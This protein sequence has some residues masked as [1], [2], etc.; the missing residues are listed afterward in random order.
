MPSIC[1]PASLP[2]ADMDTIPFLRVPA[3]RAPHSTAPANSVMEA[4][5]TAWRRE[6]A[7]LDTA[8]PN[9]LLTYMSA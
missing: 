7:R 5:M 9:V 1:T 2:N 6:R 3:T 4:R 8:G